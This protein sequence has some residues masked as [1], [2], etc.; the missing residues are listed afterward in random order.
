MALDAQ[1]DGYLELL[2][3]RI[4][5]D[6]QEYKNGTVALE[7]MTYMAQAL[8]KSRKIY[9]NK[10]KEFLNTRLVRLSIIKTEL[11]DTAE[12]LQIQGKYDVFVENAKALYEVSNSMDEMNAGINSTIRIFLK[13]I[14][15]YNREEE[16]IS[17]RLRMYNSILDYYVTAEETLIE[18]QEKITALSTG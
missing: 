17:N 5:R 10:S 16:E 3:D 6:G 2:Q 15:N 1:V 9:C 14:N 7:E 4:Y 18:L 11:V 8:I 12:A 13:K